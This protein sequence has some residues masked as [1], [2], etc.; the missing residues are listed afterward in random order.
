MVKIS[1]K[2]AGGSFSPHWSPRI[3]LRRTVSTVYK[4][5]CKSSVDVALCRCRRAKKSLLRRP[6]IGG[7]YLSAI[8]RQEAHWTMLGVAN[9]IAFSLGLNRLVSERTLR[10]DPNSPLHPIHP[11]SRRYPN[12][13]DRE[14]GRRVWLNLVRSRLTSKSSGEEETRPESQRDAAVV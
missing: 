5:S 8:G 4:R 3:G 13:I 7:I 10:A 11:G 14:I 12:L 1:P 6:S 2:N 9:K